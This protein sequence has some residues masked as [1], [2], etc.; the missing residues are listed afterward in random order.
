MATYQELAGTQADGTRFGQS[1]TSLIGFYGATPV[2]RGAGVATVATTAP[3]ASSSSSAWCY[4]S[5][6]QALAII[7]AVNALITRFN[8]YGL[9]LQS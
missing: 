7:T 4:S 6:A 5:S 2:A 8:A 3:V 1:S 9:I